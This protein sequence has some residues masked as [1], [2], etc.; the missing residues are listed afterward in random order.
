MDAEAALAAD[1]HSGGWGGKE[2]GFCVDTAWEDVNDG[3]EQ[4]DS[5]DYRDEDENLCLA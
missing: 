5:V 4:L 3:V 2:T 1:M